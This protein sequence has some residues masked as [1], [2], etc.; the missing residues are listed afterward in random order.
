MQNYENWRQEKD[1]IQSYLRHERGHILGTLTRTLI[2]EVEVRPKWG[3]NTNTNFVNDLCIN[4]QIQFREFDLEN[5]KKHF[6][7]V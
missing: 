5:L 1:E 7:S 4:I 2:K 3:Y 6:Q